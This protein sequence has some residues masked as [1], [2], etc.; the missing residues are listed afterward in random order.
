MAVSAPY[1][2][3]RDWL[4]AAQSLPDLPELRPAFDDAHQLGLSE[5]VD[6]AVLV[7]VIQGAEPSVLLT[8][9]T[10]H[11]AKHAGQVSFPGGR[12]DPDDADATATALR[13]AREEIG[14][15]AALVEI[16]GCLPDYHTGTGYRITPVVAVLPE[17]RELESLGLILCADEVEAVFELKLSIVLDADAP[18]LFHRAPPEDERTFWQLPHQDHQIWGATAAI[19]VWLGTRLRAAAGNYSCGAPASG[20]SR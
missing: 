3:L 13:E 17:G 4:T 12:R 20:S 18:Q 9:R 8:K 16:I 6:S 7:A 2:S 19:L 10:S 5:F 11:L 15:D 14:L 1:G